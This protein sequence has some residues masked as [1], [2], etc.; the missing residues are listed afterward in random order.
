MLLSNYIRYSNYRPS[1]DLKISADEG[2]H[3]NCVLI[4]S[5]LDSLSCE[6]MSIQKNILGRLDLTYKDLFIQ[7]PSRFT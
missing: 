1:I 7:F 5:E 2:K 6:M 3:S 4:D